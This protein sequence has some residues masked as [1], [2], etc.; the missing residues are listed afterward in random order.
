M[1]VVYNYRCP[2]CSETDERLVRREN[3]HNQWCKACTHHSLLT[4]LPAAPRTTFRF[5]DEKLKR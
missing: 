4:R 3:A 2:E 5:A 1:Y